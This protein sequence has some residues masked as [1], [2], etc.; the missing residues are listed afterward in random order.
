MPNKLITLEN[1]QQYTEELKENLSKIVDCDT[2]LLIKTTYA[3]LVALR[4]SG[5]L[6]PG[7]S[8]QITDYQTVVN[9]TN[10]STAGNQFDII[11]FAKA[12]DQLD[13]CAKAAHH[14]SDESGYV[15]Y[16]ANCNLDS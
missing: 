1:L 16:F 14:E 13:E 7:A 3:D 10:F 5:Q 6:I 8:Y 4:D 2:D 12:T 11:V 9:Q 15:D